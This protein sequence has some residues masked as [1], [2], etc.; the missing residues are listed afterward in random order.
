VSDRGVSPV[1]ASVLLVAITVIA[2]IMLSVT[3]LNITP[4]EPLPQATFSLSADSTTQTITLIHR[5]GAAL[6][7]E[8][9]RVRIAVNG[10]SIAHQPPVPFFAAEGYMSGPTGPFNSADE[11]Q[12]VAG[13][14]ASVQLASTNTQ[15]R[16]GAEITIRLYVDG[17]LLTVLETQA[18]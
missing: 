6:D 11:G 3:V 10:E 15:F 13:Q 17:Q 7:P 12:W 16:V 1:I 4:T 14:S 2:A 9:L 5:G 8:S 18:E